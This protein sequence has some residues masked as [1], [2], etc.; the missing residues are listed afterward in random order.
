MG[1]YATSVWG[2]KLLV[3]AGAV[4]GTHQE[5]D[6]ENDRKAKELLKISDRFQVRRETETRDR[7][8]NRDRD[9]DRDKGQWQRQ[10]QRKRRQRQLEHAYF[11]RSLRPHTRVAQ[12]LIHLYL[13]AS[14]TCTLRPDRQ[15]RFH[16][17][18]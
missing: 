12:G 3:Y 4:I 1:P 14:Y 2:L 11:T 13:K 18:N 15:V 10:R 7:D 8:R 6:Q 5:N 17:R 16:G 9:R